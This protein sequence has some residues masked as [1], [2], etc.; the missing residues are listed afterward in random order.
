MPMESQLV[1]ERIEKKYLL[2][3]AQLE[4]LRPLLQQHLQQDAYGRHTIASLYY[5]TPDYRLIRAS[6]EKPVYKEKLR[7]RSYGTP[8]SGST[9][10]VELKKKYKG[11]VYKR[12]E[13]MP[14]RE[15]EIY[16]SGGPLICPRNQILREIDAFCAQ[17]HP[18][19][20]VVLSYERV[21]MQD[22]EDANLRVTFDRD[23][24]WRSRALSLQNGTSGTPLALDGK[25]LMEVK[26]PQ[27]MPLWM[28]HAFSELAIW[29]V[30]FSKYGACYTEC[31]AKIPTLAPYCGAA[32]EK[33]DANYA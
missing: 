24:R 12:R 29:P 6:L 10:F 3:P 32:N 30:S 5:D 20:K 16:L 1:F 11:V 27:A 33:G 2:T 7:L 14:L 19:P 31:L 15:A 25:I 17:Y 9:V 26:I 4:Q 21:A 18:V 23:I 13:G 28:A 8:Q 22:R